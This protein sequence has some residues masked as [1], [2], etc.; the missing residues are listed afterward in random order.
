MEIGRFQQ[1]KIA[2]I[3]ALLIGGIALWSCSG[4]QPGLSEAAPPVVTDA[5]RPAG[6]L[7]AEWL[8]TQPGR[9]IGGFSFHL[10]D[11]DGAVI[12]DWPGL[13]VTGTADSGGASFTL[14]GT[15]LSP[16]DAYLYVVYD[17][18]CFAY[19]QAQLSPVARDEYITLAVP[20]RIEDVLVIGLARVG[21]HRGTGA[22]AGELLSLVFSAGPEAVQRAVSA[23]NDDPRSVAELSASGG[24]DYLVADLWWT[25]LNIG[26]YNNNGLVE[27]ADLTPIGIYYNQE[28]AAA[29]DPELLEVVDGNRDG[30]ITVHDITPIGQNYNTH[31]DG[32]RLYAAFTANPQTA[33]FKLYPA[34]STAIYP[35]DT[36]Y[37]LMDE[38]AKK[39]RLVYHRNDLPVEDPSGVWQGGQVSFQVRAYADDDGALTEG[40]A[41]NAVQLTYGGLPGP[42]DWSDP[43][44]AAG[45]TDAWG[46]MVDGEAGVWVEFGDA[47]DVDGDDVYYRLYYDEA[48]GFL[49]GEASILE[50]PE[51]ELTGDPPYQVFISSFD[52]AT[53]QQ[54]NS[55][56]L[57]RGT[58]YA[59]Y[60]TAADG[61]LDDGQAST[62]N[63][64]P[65]TAHPPAL[66]ES[67]EP[68][69]HYRADAQRTGCNPD[70]E[71]YEPVA[72]EQLVDLVGGIPTYFTHTLISAEGWAFCPDAGREPGKV[73]LETGE[74]ST[75]GTLQTPEY[76]F[77]AL[78]DNRRIY[79]DGAQLSTAVADGSDER[80]ASVN[81][82]VPLL[83]LGD[84][85][86]VVSEGGD[87]VCLTADRLIE[88]WR[89][90]LDLMAPPDTILAPAADDEYVYY[91]VDQMLFKYDLL[92][93]ASAGQA[94]LAFPPAGDSLALDK[95]NQRLYIAV[96]SAA[97]T[98]NTVLI[99]YNT[100]DLAESQRFPAQGY[101]FASSAPCLALHAD[102]PVVFVACR[103]THVDEQNALLAYDPATGFA[104]WQAWQAT[105]GIT[106]I[107]C[108]MDRIFG[109]TNVMVTW[110]Y[111]FSGR[112]RQRYVRPVN[113]EVTLASDLGL[114]NGQ[115]L[116]R[117]TTQT[118]DPPPYY[119][120]G[121][122]GIQQVTTDD[123][124]V[125]LEWAP[126]LD[127]H[128]EVVSFAIYVSTN[129]PIEYNEP[130]TYT[131]VYPGYSGNV[132][133]TTIDGLDNGTRY[134]FAVRAYDG[135]WGE[136]ENLEDNDSVLG[137]T[138]PW[139]SERLILGDDLPAGE[140]FFMR[141]LINA[142]DEMHL[143]YN[144]E[145]DG[146][147][148]HLWGTTGS[149]L[150]EAVDDGLD[151]NLSVQCMEPA[152]DAE[153]GQIVIAYANQS[154]GTVGYLAR[155][156]LG[157]YDQTVFADAT[158]AQNPQVALAIGTEWAQAYT[159]D[160][161]DVGLED[162]VDYYLKRTVSGVWDPYEPAEE[163]N[164]AGRDLDLVLDPADGT[165]PWLA[166][167]R[168]GESTP[169]RHTP[170]DGECL[171]ARWDSLNTE[172][173]YEL[174][175]AGDNAP[176]SDCGKRVQQ[177][178][179]AAGNPHLAYLD[180]DASADDPLGQLK[181]ADYDGADWQVEVVDEFDL[182]FQ[183]GNLQYTWG[184]LGLALV[185]DGAGGQLPVIAIHDRLTDS[186]PGEPHRSRLLVW[187]RDSE[188]DWQPEQLT[189]T[190]WLF[191]RDR[192]PCVLLV[193]S[194]QVAHVFYVTDDD[195]LVPLSANAI[196]HYWR[197][198]PFY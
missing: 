15:A 42:P 1:S 50:V 14:V 77:G 70:C 38:L 174:V 160:I 73:D 111:D 127:E 22:V 103:K 124:E 131:T 122:E 142:A 149:W 46:D 118:P 147:L 196:V 68:W 32:Y 155:N 133:S 21:A 138:P 19:R 12:A 172:W 79:S 67:S 30:Y 13:S 76:F 141:G 197:P 161:F 8:S 171:Y 5:N 86:Y 145:A 10:L 82:G 185:D 33:D 3:L 173:D 6:K 129:L 143:V 121:E 119:P 148:M 110:V 130:R 106:S 157:L 154:L 18:G 194:A 108:S 186:D 115:Y 117:V 184:E 123:G 23:V 34:A 36:L 39:K 62:G 175:D 93:G 125:S 100:N 26:D 94:T 146:Q 88:Q 113:R 71:L 162:H 139:Q 57:A 64:S 92:T 167:Q 84:L 69:S 114:L 75:F 136:D 95:A 132:T 178:L 134:W 97:E 126:A 140:A 177:V 189:D 176:D 66:G 72:A 164:L 101:Y 87:I 116:Q 193:D 2:A 107:T 45:I 91:A 179:D 40:P 166:V 16:D 190:E 78:G 96:N 56:P 65:L 183:T 158:P 29:D 4:S 52:D 20:G 169:N 61:P 89:F 43:V 188:G 63:N 163:T 74:W 24:G 11:A 153:A 181:Y 168:G 47:Y 152:W 105:Y 80:L 137:A 58:D 109:A 28:V 49:F 191:P 85:L 128:G 17:G 150:A 159:Q 48:D 192:E 120:G 60:V 156:V 170:E 98:D 187:V 112:H 44:N 182:S 41:S 99:E 7:T 83:L 81:C 144:H 54:A 9:R 59:F 102:P 35:R 90:D 51:S 165:S 104:R 53:V 27:V 151:N 31:I 198:V 55:G 135:L 25:E 37:N 195:N 180:L